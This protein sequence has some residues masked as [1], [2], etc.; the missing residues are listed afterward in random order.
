MLCKV[1]S[2]F[3]GGQQKVNTDTLFT[4]WKQVVE[5]VHKK[6]N[7]IKFNQEITQLI[8]HMICSQDYLK[9]LKNNQLKNHIGKLVR[10]QQ[11]YFGMDTLH[12]VQKHY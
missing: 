10:I 2:S 1:V 6:P 5:F 4:E 3:R 9:Q 8:Q 7:V 12:Q 11:Q